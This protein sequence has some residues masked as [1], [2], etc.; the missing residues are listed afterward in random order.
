M[1]VMGSEG[2]TRHFWNIQKS[3]EIEMARK[4]FDLYIDKKY[5]AFRMNSSGDAGEI[6]EAFDS[7][8]GCILFIPPMQ[9][10]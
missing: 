4:V 2:D 9:G 7:E 3:D 8:A 5:R 10:G 6:L 1:A